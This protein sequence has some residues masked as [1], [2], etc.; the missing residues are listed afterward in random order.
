MQNGWSTPSDV[1]GIKVNCSGAPGIMSSPVVVA[2]I[3]RNGHL[4][5]MTHSDRSSVSRWSD[6]RDA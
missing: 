3:V 2:E 1:V 5:R 4:G 6:N